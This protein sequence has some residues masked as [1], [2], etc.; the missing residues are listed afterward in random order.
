[1]GTYIGHILDIYWS[2][3][4]IYSWKVRKRGKIKLESIYDSIYDS[5]ISDS[6]YDSI[7]SDSIY[8]SIISDSIYDSMW[9]GVNGSEWMN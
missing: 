7:I 9:M 8:D 5:I 4:Q 1:M 3:Q 2:V 6:I